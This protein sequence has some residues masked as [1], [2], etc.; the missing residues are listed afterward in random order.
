MGAIGRTSDYAASY[1]RIFGGKYNGVDANMEAY[2]DFYCMNK[3]GG[4]VK[5]VEATDSLITIWDTVN[6]K[7]NLRVD[8]AISAD[9]IKGRA[10]SMNGQSTMSSSPIAFGCD[11]GTV[12]S[13]TSNLVMTNS[14]K[15]KIAIGARNV[16]LNCNGEVGYYVW[17]DTSVGNPLDIL[18]INLATT[19]VD[20]TLSG[21]TGNTWRFHRIWVDS[22][23]G[24]APATL[25][26][27]HTD[28][29]YSKNLVVTDIIHGNKLYTWYA[30]IG[31]SLYAY[32]LNVESSINT[33]NLYATS[34]CVADSV[35]SRKLNLSNS[36]TWACTLSGFT[37]V[38]ALTVTYYKIGPL[39]VLT[40]PITSAT[41]NSTEMNTNLIPATIHPKTVFDVSLP[42]QDNSGFV[43]GVAESNGDGK[44]HF[45]SSNR[46]G[47]SSSNSKGVMYNVLSYI[48]DKQ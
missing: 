17:P 8:K 27:T 48:T 29:L 32:K 21:T 44:I 23:Y 13:N 5:I 19:N 9:S 2:L 16:N 28:S 22:L 1:A 10:Y 26:V 43:T 3:N 11:Y 12:F 41:S 39:V 45:Y 40:F 18:H 33:I 15:T 25:G 42:L 47:F 14:N 4:E 38:V 36:G 6:M 20:A 24:S 7:Q 31:D 46:T 35:Y 34:N 37:S 30:T